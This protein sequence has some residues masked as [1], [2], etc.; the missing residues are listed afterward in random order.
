[1]EVRVLHPRMLRQHTH[2]MP[3]CTQAARQKVGIPFRAAEL[4]EKR[5]SEQAYP[6]V[7][8]SARVGRL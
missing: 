1:M 6:Q 3:P 8:T 4:R 7:E 5:R 2:V